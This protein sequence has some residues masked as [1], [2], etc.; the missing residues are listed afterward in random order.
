MFR[1]L[2]VEDDIVLCKQLKQLLSAEYRVEVARSIEE[3]DAVLES[4]KVDLVLLDR[5]VSDGDTIELLPYI[6]EC[7]PATRILMMSSRAAVEERING[8]S[9]GA[10]DY[11]PKPLDPQEVLW[12]ARRLLQLERAAIEDWQQVGVLRFN[13]LTGE[14][15]SGQLLVHL[16]PREAQILSCLLR[17]K[18]RVVTRNTI[19]SHVW[20]SS[21]VPTNT[22]IDVYLRRLRMMLGETA[23]YIETV[24]GFG[25]LI[26][27]PA[28]T[29]K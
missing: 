26:R 19:V 24:R 21:E 29:Y 11:V 14:T 28:V 25:Y 18:N 8:L 10:D 9:Q 22:T 17:F 16:R 15:Y 6:R 20:G 23:S 4:K 13:R 27:D 12:R 1:V 7:S 5:L 2:I 3:T